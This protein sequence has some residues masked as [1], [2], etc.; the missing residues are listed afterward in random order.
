MSNYPY[1]GIG[2]LRSK[3]VTVRRRALTRYDYYEIKEGHILPKI[4]IPKELSCA[5]K[6]SI[7]WCTKAVDALAD[8]LVVTGFENDRMNMQS[9]FDLNHADVLFDS[10]ILGALITSC[11]FIYISQNEDGSPRMQVID[12]TNATGVIDP[13][14]NMLVEG[15]AVL[16]RDLKTENPTMEAYFVPGETTF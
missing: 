16:E 10:A 5:Y 12:G 13:V 4:A 6:S 3:L 2:Y 8:R 7:G 9:I 1:R 15:Y 11:D 14:T